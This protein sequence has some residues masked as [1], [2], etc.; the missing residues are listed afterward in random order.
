MKEKTLKETFL[1]D[2]NLL[3]VRLSGKVFLAVVSPRISGF[4]VNRMDFAGKFIENV[5]GVSVFKTLDLIS[6]VDD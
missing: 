3:K 1:E 4:M 2:K 5:S 6:F